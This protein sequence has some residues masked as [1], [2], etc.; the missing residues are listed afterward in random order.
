MDATQKQKLQKL[1]QLANF[2]D[3]LP[4]SKFHMPHW[5]S[6]DATKSSCGTAGCAAGW[7][8]TIFHKEGWSI[9][10]RF[11]YFNDFYGEFAFSEFFGISITESIYI[12]KFLDKFIHHYHMPNPSLVSY[13]EEF[14]LK[15]ADDI[16]PAMAAIRIRKVV[17]GYDPS[18][19]EDKTVPEYKKEPCK[20]VSTFA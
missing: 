15:S 11:V 12:T 8:A 10:N 20:N 9:L 5:A 6:E 7:A 13:V 1:V 18:L 17:A 2:L 4:H 14:D 16:T 19:L 3:D